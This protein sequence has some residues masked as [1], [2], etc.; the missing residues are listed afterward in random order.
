[1]TTIMI[2][3]GMAIITFSIRYLLP[4]A[5]DRIKLP[6]AFE[7]ALRFVPPAVLSAIIFPGLL[8]P[9]G[10]TFDLGFDNRYLVCGLIAF[11]VGLYRQN[12]LLTIVLGMG[13]FLLWHWVF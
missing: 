8:I 1:M 9:D 3:L 4:A 5:S 2:I 6:A 10:K 12:L 11:A 7:Q 13:S